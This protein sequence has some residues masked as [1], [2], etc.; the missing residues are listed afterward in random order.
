MPRL[1]YPGVTEILL[2]R[3]GETDWNREGRLQGWADL[4]LNERGREQAR[5][6]ARTLA[7]EPI[8]A[9]YTSD[10]AR[11]RETGEI[12]AESHGV[13]VVVDPGLRE[14]DV[15][16]WEGLTLSEIEQRFPGAEHHDGEAREAHQARVVAAVE[17]IAHDHPG[18][19]ILLVSHGGSLRA[20][21]R[22]CIGEPLH[23]IENCG[24]F[25]LRF[26]DGA[27]SAVE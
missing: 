7:A 5:G 15:G 20:L 3:H 11:A 17:R 26:K 9:V 13:P 24:V 2:A 19:R 4:P 21:R 14:I 25:Q 6:L 10:L 8:D 18:G 22:H 16:S 12:V 27:F 23:P 1:A